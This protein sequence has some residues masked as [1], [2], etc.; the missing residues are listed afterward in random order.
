MIAMHEGGITAI[1][2]GP[3]VARM[4]LPVIDA[5]VL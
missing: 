4:S 2:S 1:V 3:I 5:S